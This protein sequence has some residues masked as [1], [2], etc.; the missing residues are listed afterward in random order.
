VSGAA[1]AS[2]RTGGPARPR[3]HAGTGRLLRPFLARHWGALAGAGVSTVALSAATL[4][5]PWPLKLAIDHLIGDHNGRF[6]LSGADA[7]LL[8]GLAG[9]VLAI[10]MVDAVATYLSDFWLNR[11]GERIVHDLRVA[12]YAHLQ[13]LSLAFHASRPKGDLV[14]RITGDV[15]EVGKLFSDII[16]T[17]AQ[18]VLTLLG[19][20]VVSF[21]LDPVLAAAAFLVSPLLFAVT[22]HYQRTIKQMARRQRAK[23]GEIASLANEALSAMQVVKAFGAERFE[24]ERVLRRSAERLEAGVRG[25]RMEA[26]FSG[27]VDVL[28]SVATAVVLALGVLRVASGHL[29]P[30]DL[31]VFVSYTN[32]LYRPLRDIARQTSYAARSMARLDRIGEI[33][34][35]E[36]ILQ[37]RPGAFRGGRARGD[38]E[39]RHVEFG[40]GPGRP[41]LA[42]VSLSLEAGTKLALVGPSGAGKSTVGALVARFHDPVYGR[43]L[44]DGRDARDCSPVWLR[45]QVGVLLQDTILFSGT[46]ADNIAYGLQ[47]DRAAVVAAAT[48]ACADEFVAA[49]PDG[50]DTVLGPGGIGLSGGQRQRIGIARVLLRDP[51][52]LVLDE[53]TTGLDAHS[54]GRVLRGLA[55]LIRGRTTIVITHSAALA[56][57]ADRVAVMER[58]RIVE[59]GTPAELLGRASGFRRLVHE[60]AWTYSAGIRGRPSVGLPRRQ[61]PGG[62]S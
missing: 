26:R 53:P 54:E 61:A 5:A 25:S 35:S 40:Y 37:E 44:I 59:E 42:D 22:V 20:A 41:A 50:Y 9:L 24:H 56:S 36:Q 8:A 32:R 29:S 19:M 49:L 18:A 3:R 62:S 28:G 38:L 60:Q 45:D 39:L 52:I 6:S 1:P 21:E 43:V 57:T 31:V 34:A 48:A 11:S 16:G 51:P 14:T 7:A 55:A 46:V 10:A 30:G 4:A 27:V 17:F 23:E 58:G 33:L 15:N 12:T 13:R 2:P 47:A